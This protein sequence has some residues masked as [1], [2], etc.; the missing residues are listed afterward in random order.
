MEFFLSRVEPGSNLDVNISKKFDQSVYVTPAKYV[1]FF[2][3]TAQ[4]NFEI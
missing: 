3:T 1:N 4:S 2:R